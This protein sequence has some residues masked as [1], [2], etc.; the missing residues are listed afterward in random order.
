MPYLIDGHNLIPKIPGFSLE[1]MDDEMQLVE[2]LQEFCR[3]QRKEAEVY[4]DNAPPGQK[5]ARVFGP[6]TAHFVR[7]GTTADDAIRARLGRLGRDA[8]NWTVVSS[9]H[10]VQASAR[11]ARAHYIPSEVFAGTLAQTIDKSRQDQGER[12]ESSLDDDELDDWL[13]LFGS[14]EN[15]DQPPG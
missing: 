2:L 8:R 7:Q 11:A 3:R 12:T 4:F 9:D 10:N 6:V 14:D 13:K 5:Q 1:T 15:E